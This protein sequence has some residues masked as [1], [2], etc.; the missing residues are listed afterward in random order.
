MPRDRQ[1]NKNDPCTDSEST[2]YQQIV[3]MLNWLAKQT[4]PNIC[5]DVCQLTSPL[6]NPIIA[7][8]VKANKVLRRIKEN[9]LVV[10]FPNL[11]ELDQLQLQCYS[12]ASLAN[13]SSGKSAGGHVIFLVGQNS[14][15]CPLS[16]KTKTLRVVR[17]TLSAE[18]SAMVDALD[19]TYFL[20]NVLSEVLFLTSVF[21]KMAVNRVPILAFTDNE[22]LYRTVHST[23]MTNEHR[24]RIDIAVIKQMMS[25]NELRSI[26]WIP[27]TE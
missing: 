17:S 22:S 24:L 18:T 6:K 8:I 9:P 10:R 1:A 19:I 25:Q 27:G 11:G 26:N 14:N 23:V 3:G 4:R 12:D 2:Q 13:L 16:W 7:N 15:A 5:F 21:H 20:S